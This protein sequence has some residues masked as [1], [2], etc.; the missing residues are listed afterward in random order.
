MPLRLASD[1][2]WRGA[3]RG[4]IAIGAAAISISITTKT[5]TGIQISIAVST[6]AAT[7]AKADADK[8]PGDLSTIQSTAKAFLTAT[9][10]RRKNSTEPAPTTRLSPESSFADEPNREDKIS[11]AEISVTGVVLVDKAALAIVP[12]KAVPATE[13]VQAPVAA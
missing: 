11:A 9:K 8:G 10:G 1:L 5:S 12:G 13:V 3:M 7:A 6:R 4:E 2:G